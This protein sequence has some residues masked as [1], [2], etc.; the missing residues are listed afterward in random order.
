MI[1]TPVSNIDDVV[2][3]FLLIVIRK[4]YKK[5][6]MSFNINVICDS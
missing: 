3:C 5:Y 6:V 1:I 2:R 4:L